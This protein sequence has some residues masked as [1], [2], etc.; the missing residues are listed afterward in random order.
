MTNNTA[1][2]KSLLFYCLLLLSGVLYYCLAYQTTRDNFL[3]VILLF[4]AL[5]AIY[6]FLHKFFFTTHFK[7]LLIAGV[8][9]RMLLLFSVPNLSDDVYRFVWD[10]RLAANGINPFS[11]LP[12]EIMQMPTITGLTSELFSQLNSP[13]Y[14]SIYPPVLQGI[15][16]LAAKLAPVD[17]SDTIVVMKCMIIIVEFCI[18][19]LLVRLLQ[20]CSLPKHLSLLYF[21][22]PLIIIELTGNAHFE[23]IMISTL[24]FA[25]LLFL[26]NNWQASAIC[27]GLGIATK[28][29]PVLFLPLLISRLGWKKGLLYA[30]LTGATTI[31]LFAIA[32][33]LET[34][35]HLLKSAD[36]FIRQFE[37]NASLY[38]VVRWIGTGLTGYNIIANA[39]PAMLLLASVLIICLS[40][41]KKN[42][43]GT[44]LFKTTLFI[45][46][47]W[48]LFSTT[49]HPWYLC[50]PVA[51]SVFTSYRFA[52][53]WSL[54]AVLSYAAYQ[55]NPV[56]ENLW[57][58]STGYILMIGYAWWEIRSSKQLDHNPGKL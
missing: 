32:F 3:Q 44:Q 42:I 29:V 40:L 20:A 33:D 13:N 37:F 36:L 19:F 9:F 43:T 48:Y 47:A 17:V 50:L 10:G 1:S 45:I 49:V 39:G 56:K 7:Y 25:F 14:Y 8:L 28:L 5:F 27:L 57:L 41:H 18:C 22:N 30:I 53:I 26:K 2:T 16:W 11:H 35:I 12:I 38:Y 15:F 6:F 24:L 46:A 4:S 23:G 55:S 31:V 54:T 58:I 21:L 52:I 51:L 34:I